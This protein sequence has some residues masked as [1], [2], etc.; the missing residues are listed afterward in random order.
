MVEFSSGNFTSSI[1]LK[2]PHSAPTSSA[3][4]TQAAKG[5]PCSPHQPATQ[6]ESVMIEAMEISISPSTSTIMVP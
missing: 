5:N 4:Q 1:P 6:A 3:T 2:A